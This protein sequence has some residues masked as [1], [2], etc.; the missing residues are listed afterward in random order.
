MKMFSKESSKKKKICLLFAL[1]LHLLIIP[2]SICSAG[3]NGEITISAALSLREAFTAMSKSFEAGRKGVKVRLNFGS[4]GD[5]VRQ[6]EGGAPVEVFASASPKEMDMLAKQGLIV[7]STRKNFAENAMVLVTALDS[8]S[9]IYS[10]KDLASG[11]IKKIAVGNFKTVPAGRYAEEIF[12]YFNLMPLIKDKL[13]FAENIKQVLDY[14]ARKEVEA[15]VVY[16]TD[17]AQR[18]HEIKVAAVADKKSHSRVVYPIAL[19]KN[20]RNPHIAKDFMSY[21]FSAE[22]Q[23]I[24]EE[25]G[26]DPVRK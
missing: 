5:L 23:K 10:F 24:L 15:G 6:I 8:R 2:V 21:I 14:V 11:G 26:F 4:S 1:T 18:K 19:I 20:T 22:G 3:T 13:I 7:S 25:Y 17:A 12:Q 16:A 9:R